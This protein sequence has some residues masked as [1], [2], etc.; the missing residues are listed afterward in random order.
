[1]TTETEL[2]EY[3]ARMKSEI[4]ETDLST[5][6]GIRKEENILQYLTFLANSEVFGIN[7]LQTHEVLKPVFI[8][9]L[10]NVEPEV[11]GV[12][13]LRG[14]IIP[15]LDINMKFGFQYTKLTPQ[16][17]IIIATYKKQMKGL[18]V[19]KV[20]EVARIKEESIQAAEIHNFSNHY[21]EGTGRVENKIFQ[22][23]NLET[24]FSFT[25]DKD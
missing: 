13:N 19:D 21:V 8:T 12:I 11:L 24:I 17:R 22:I 3:L 16:T 7:I 4:D 18:L 6:D 1:L 10:P 15:V 25:S 20:Q 9:R 23:L 5:T 2:K 14:N